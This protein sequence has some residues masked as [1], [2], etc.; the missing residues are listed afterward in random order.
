MPASRR[1]LLAATTSGVDT[2]SL[3]KKN[4]TSPAAPAH[5]VINFVEQTGDS[6]PRPEGRARTVVELHAAIGQEPH[7]AAFQG[8]PDLLFGSLMRRGNRAA[9]DAPYR[10]GVAVVCFRQSAVV[11]VYQFE[12]GAYLTRIE[13]YCQ[14]SS[15]ELP[16]FRTPFYNT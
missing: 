14:Y 15:N 5:R 11:P 12:R 13:H 9:A 16:A 2:W 3:T 4:S 6:C 8:F 1:R 10:I 7:A